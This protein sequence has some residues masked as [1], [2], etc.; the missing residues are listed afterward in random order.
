[1]VTNGPKKIF[2]PKSMINNRKELR[3]A[4]CAWAAGR[5]G[6]LA[7]IGDPG[8]SDSFSSDILG[9]AV[10]G[11]PRRGMVLGGKPGFETVC[12]ETG[13]KAWPGTSCIKKLELACKVIFWL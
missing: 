9:I 12:F 3:L 2:P 7:W 6:I 1:M 4:S 5:K 13:G 11:L 8:S 10:E